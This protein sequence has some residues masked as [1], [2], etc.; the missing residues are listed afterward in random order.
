MLEKTIKQLLLLVGFLL[1]LTFEK[2]VGFPIL[3]FFL[4]A[5]LASTW[6]SVMRIVLILIAAVL[7]SGLFAFSIS[8]VV[9]LMGALVYGWIASSRLSDRKNSARL[10]L[11][12]VLSIF[13]AVVN[14]S[15]FSNQLVVY[16]L[17]SMLFSWYLLEKS[18]YAI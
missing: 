16:A 15:V 6:P 12:T 10:I 9:I 13:V 17:F 1:I 11:I 2:V 7:F 4:I 8:W 18:A 3:S 5:V 14:Q